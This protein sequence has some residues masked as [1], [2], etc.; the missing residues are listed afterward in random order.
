MEVK[1]ELHN[2]FTSR[3]LEFGRVTVV[4]GWNQVQPTPFSFQNINASMSTLIIQPPNQTL[5]EECRNELGE[6]LSVVL[7]QS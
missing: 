6:I 5:K 1:I 4:K 3:F 7:Y 2:Q